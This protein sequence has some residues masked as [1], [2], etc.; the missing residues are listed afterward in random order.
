MTTRSA[1][2]ERVFPLEE[3]TIRAQGDGRTVDAY[4]AVFNRAVAISDWEGEY[5]E[6][7]RPGAFRKTIAEQRAGFQVFYNHGKNIYGSPAERYAMPLGAPVE[8]REDTKGLWTVTR[9]AA[10][11]LA[12]E[13]LELIRAGAIRG[14]S[15]SGHWVQSREISPARPGQ[16]PTIERLEVAMREYG[17]TPFPAYKDA[18]IA[19]VR[20][21]E[22]LREFANLSPDERVE[23]ARALA[24]GTPLEAALAGTETPEPPDGTDTPDQ[25]ADGAP[26]GEGPSHDEAAVTELELRRRR[27]AI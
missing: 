14:Q 10:T 3:I 1:T 23:L 16:L 12:D 21:T 17:P 25:A 13:V 2:F 15:F 20:S 5:E 24:T 26:A 19:G 22:L 9:Y 11:P 4:A 18:A 6:I 8:V 27:L 7:I